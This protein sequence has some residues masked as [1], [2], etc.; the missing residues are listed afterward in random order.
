M[1][2]SHIKTQP[3]KTELTMPLHTITYNIT[4]RFLDAV[5]N[6]EEIKVPN[7]NPTINILSGV[8]CPIE[9]KTLIRTVLSANDFCRITRVMPS[10]YDT[11][12]KNSLRLTEEMYQNLVDHIK[13]AIPE[14]T[15]KSK[16]S[17]NKN[18]GKQ[19][20]VE[21]RFQSKQTDEDIEWTAPSSNAMQTR[22]AYLAKLLQNRRK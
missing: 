14:E 8:W 17:K 6:G 21:E 16:K 7:M 4:E 13:T 20:I 3:Q 2:Y 9:R 1:D 19:R 10:A 11:R 5:K 18:Q 12:G 15:K 22:S